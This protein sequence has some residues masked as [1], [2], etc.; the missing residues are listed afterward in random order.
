MR[1]KRNL[2]MIELAEKCGI[3]RTVLYRIETGKL[4]PRLS[5][6]EK[7]AAGFE[8][9]VMELLEEVFV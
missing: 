9:N 4:S 2:S 3:D 6:V 7:L 1:K 5:Q 8:V